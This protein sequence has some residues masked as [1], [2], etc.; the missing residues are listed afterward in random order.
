MKLRKVKIGIIGVGIVGGAI[1]TGFDAVGHKVSV[2][3]LRLDTKID[4]V[5]DT[6]VCFLCVPTPSRED[7]SYNTSIVE[8]VITE[9]PYLN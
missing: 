9:L 5:I 7:G 2:H 1:K 6:E 8:G 3:A 4:D